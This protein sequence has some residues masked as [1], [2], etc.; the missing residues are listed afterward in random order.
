MTIGPS[1]LEPSGH[2]WAGSKRLR[3]KEL[4]HTGFTTGYL[5][6]LASISMDFESLSLMSWPTAEQTTCIELV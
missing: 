2:S 1:S 5:S 4:T 3:E 6:F